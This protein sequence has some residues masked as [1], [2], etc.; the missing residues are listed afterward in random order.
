MSNIYKA[1]KIETKA[2]EEQQNLFVDSGNVNL[3]SNARKNP[4][5][6]AAKEPFNFLPFVLMIALSVHSIFEGLALGLMKDF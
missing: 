2:Q 5:A 6:P 4:A 1:S 3:T